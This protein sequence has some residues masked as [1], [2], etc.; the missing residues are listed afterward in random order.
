ML[1]LEFI[2]SANFVAVTCSHS[3]IEQTTQRPDATQ[4]NIIILTHN[5]RRQS[6]MHYKICIQFVYDYYNCTLYTTMYSQ[7]LAVLNKN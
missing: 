2:D 7:N 3:L 1:Q 5:I 6:I 4:I